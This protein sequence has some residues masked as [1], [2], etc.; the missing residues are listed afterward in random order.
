MTRFFLGA[1]LVAIVCGC[2]STTRTYDVSVKNEL[3]KPVMLW[4]TKD[5]PPSESKWRSPEEFAKMPVGEDR[6]LAGVVVQP[7]K[8]ADTG[9]VEGKFKAGTNAVLRVYV[10][11][12]TFDGIM[13][14]RQG[15][16]D[17]KLSP[18]TNE[19]VLREKNG[20]PV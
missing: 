3:N 13:R 4:L 5:G 18:G 16:M 10:G 1:V 12:T 19:F 20:M 17:L 9:P 7:G 8:I 14:M 6:V 2:G 11:E 15:R